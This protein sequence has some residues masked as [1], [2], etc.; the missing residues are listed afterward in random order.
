[1]SGGVELDSGGFPLGA[2]PG[3]AGLAGPHGVT[4]PPWAM[5]GPHCGAKRG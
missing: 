5:A 3:M 1:M 2:G 4:R